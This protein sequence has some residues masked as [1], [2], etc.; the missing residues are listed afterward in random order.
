M[1][2]L[3]S[4]IVKDGEISKILEEP[5]GYIESEKYMSWEKFFTA[6]LIEKT[7]DSYLRYEKTKLNTA[8]KNEKVAEKI[9]E[10]IPDGLI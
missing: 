3:K 5:N 1:E 6:L 8:Y 2:I 4:G 9:I 7:K 10:V